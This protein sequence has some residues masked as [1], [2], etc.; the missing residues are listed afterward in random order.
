MSQFLNYWYCL[1]LPT[2]WPANKNLMPQTR[3]L[4]MHDNSYRVV[5]RAYQQN[6]IPETTIN[7]TYPQQKFRF[8]LPWYVIDR[9]VTGD[10]LIFA[11][12]F[13]NRNSGMR[14]RLQ[15]PKGACIITFIM[16]KAV[17]KQQTNSDKGFLQNLF[18]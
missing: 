14:Y 17:K 4:F 18:S 12:K 1:L 9:N 11:L 10:V 2:P 15:P 13:Q 7:K 3:V 5:N 6:H 16:K 8:H